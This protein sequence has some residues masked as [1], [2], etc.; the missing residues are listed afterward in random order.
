LFDSVGVAVVVFLSINEV[1]GS[2]TR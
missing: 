1:A 2:Q